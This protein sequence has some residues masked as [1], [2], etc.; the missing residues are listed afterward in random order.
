M[1]YLLIVL[2][3]TETL[4][5]QSILQLQHD[6]GQMKRSESILSNLNSTADALPA[7]EKKST[8]LAV[9]YSI[10]LPGMG[11][12]YLE[13]YSSGKTFTMIDAALWVGY[14]GMDYYSKYQR[15]NFK[16]F[17]H[18]HGGLPH[19]S[20]SDAL[21]ADVGN[22]LSVKVYN[23]EKSFQRQFSDMYDPVNQYWAWDS[24]SERREYRKLW[25]SSQHAKNNLRFVIG[26][27][28]LNRAVS[29]INAVRIQIARNKKNAATS[30][31]QVG[32]SPDFSPAGGMTA[33]LLWQF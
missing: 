9:L 22:Y 12:L 25:L 26:A 4:C 20:Y 7:V 32:F 2:L 17:A 28:V 29:A 27:L 1:R 10:L 23:D 19:G 21:Y 31:M 30:T 24:Q 6:A 11:E 14:F 33:N 3:L 13:N 16:E 8:T 15:D 18:V 5:A